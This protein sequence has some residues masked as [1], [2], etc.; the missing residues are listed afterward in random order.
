MAK[1]GKGSLSSAMAQA[2]ANKKLLDQ[3]EASL[4]NLYE[5]HQ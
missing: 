3:A 1:K 4:A 5:P 2:E